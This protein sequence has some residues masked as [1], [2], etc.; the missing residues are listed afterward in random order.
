MGLDYGDRVAEEWAST[1]T[2]TVPTQAAARAVAR[3][4]EPLRACRWSPDG[5]LL[6]ALG[7]R[8]IYVFASS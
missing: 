6:A 7:D 5:R 8:S 1:Y 4:N 3:V 2:V